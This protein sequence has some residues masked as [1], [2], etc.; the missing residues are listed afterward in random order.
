M[1]SAG[2]P[3]LSIALRIS[4]LRLVTPVLESAEM[5]PGGI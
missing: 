1:N 5:T 2:C 4:A 3:Q